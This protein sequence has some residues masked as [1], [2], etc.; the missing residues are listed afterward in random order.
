M[1]SNCPT[2]RPSLATAP[3]DKLSRTR[4]WLVWVWVPSEV[5]KNLFSTPTSSV[6]PEL[7]TRA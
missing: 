3:A 6:T 2:N 7:I 5:T 4:D 1:E